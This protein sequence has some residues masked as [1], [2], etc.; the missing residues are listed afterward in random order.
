MFGLFFSFF[1]RWTAKACYLILP[2]IKMHIGSALACHLPLLGKVGWGPGFWWLRFFKF[3]F[4]LLGHSASHLCSVNSA[5]GNLDAGQSLQLLSGE[6]P[7]LRLLGIPSHFCYMHFNCGKGKRLPDLSCVGV[8]WVWNLWA[9]IN[10]D[11][12]WFW[13]LLLNFWFTSPAFGP[14]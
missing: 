10:L 12:N 6:L 3:F 11:I 5:S 4:L 14:F 13:E 9:V 7:H 2:P 1:D 8:I